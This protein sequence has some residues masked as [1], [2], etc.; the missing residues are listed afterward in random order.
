MRKFALLVLA[1]VFGWSSGAW[2]V[3]I[4]WTVESGGNGHWYEFRSVDL[5]G[6][7]HWEAARIEAEAAGGYL[8]TITSAAENS[9]FTNQVVVPFT[10]RGCFCVEYLGGYQPAGGGPSQA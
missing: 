3:P 8:A 9:F 7:H 10:R 4:Q 5:Y 1:V 2:A 6:P